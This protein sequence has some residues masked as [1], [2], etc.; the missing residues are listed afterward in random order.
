[1][2]A[3][4][5]R[6]FAIVMYEIVSRQEPYFDMADFGPCGRWLR[7]AVAQGQRPALE[8]IPAALHCAPYVALMQECWQVH[9]PSRPPFESVCSQ[10]RAMLGH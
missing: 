4:D 9:P 1:M 2:S 5:T 10:L 6:S 7:Q 8:H 3:D